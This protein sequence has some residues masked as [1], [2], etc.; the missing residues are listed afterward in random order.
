M[1]NWIL[2]QKNSKKGYNK[3]LTFLELIVV[4][5]IFGTIATVVLANFGDFTS[6]V[7][8]QNLSQDM[9]LKIKQAQIDSLSGKGG[10]MLF[11]PSAGLRPSYGVYFSTTNPTG[12]VYFKDLNN[13]GAFDEDCGNGGN[14]ECIDEISINANINGNNQGVIDGLCVKSLGDWTCPPVDDK[15]N[16]TFRR[17]Y[18]DAL[19]NSYYANPI[20]TTAIVLKSSKGQKKAILVSS[21][22]EISI[23]NISSANNNLTLEQMAIVENF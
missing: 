17:P 4:L 5:G 15:L 14:I 3:G 6:S 16:I 22:G 7:Y 12:F 21:L 19:I 8:L 2:K 1:F 10:S 13:N 11:N 18:S 9:A 23:R 20:S